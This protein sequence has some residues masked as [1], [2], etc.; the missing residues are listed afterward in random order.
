M[1]EVL[2]IAFT[3]VLL[4]IN[5]VAFRAGKTYMFVLIAIYSLTMNIFV[6]KQFTL[7]GFMITGG[8]ALY[9]ATF[10]LTDLLSE[11]YG[12]KVALK[13]VLTG[14]LTIVVFII[15]TQFLLA[16]VPNSED[17]ANES[18][19][20]L[21]TIT[22]RIL[23]GS[24]V[25]Y[26]IAQTI[27]IFIYTKIKALTH[28]KWLFIRNNGST[29]I[30]QFIDTIIFTAVGITTFSFAPGIIPLEIFWEVVL[31]TYVIKIIVALLDT[32]FMYLSYAIK[33]K[34]LQ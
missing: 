18:L 3:L 30:S 17:F 22:P 7:F 1:N 11:H 12:K 14:F 6:L 16:F 32:P 21:F 23:F 20:T 4:C 10:L 29:L 25:A 34:K 15:S 31:T 27:D 19:K 28:N 9:G 5:L 13:S 24:L 26:G 33:P 8:N 2:F